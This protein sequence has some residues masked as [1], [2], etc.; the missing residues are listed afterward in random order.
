MKRK[1]AAGE[2][3]AFRDFSRA[4]D[5]SP[6]GD[7]GLAHRL[8]RSRSDPRQRRHPHDGSVTADLRRSRNRRRAGRR[9]A[10]ART[11]GRCRHPSGSTSVAG[12]RSP[13]S[14]THTSIS[15]PGR[16]RG[17]MSSSTVRRHSRTR[18]TG[19]GA[20]PVTGRGYGV[21]AGAMPTGPR[22]RPSRRST[23]SP[24][25]LRRRCGPRTTTRCGSTRPLSPSRREISTYRE[26]SW[27]ATRTG[28]RQESCAKSL[29]GAS[30]SA[31]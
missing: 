5:P 16:S 25:T 27:N 3:D 15:P 4:P 20:T 19:W 30:G 29:H 26:A 18:S 8:S 9:A 7:P 17:A 24:A 28:A 1:P 10:S 23:P 12:A 22:S 11:S 21:P 2:A 6:A 13:P 31:G 14:R